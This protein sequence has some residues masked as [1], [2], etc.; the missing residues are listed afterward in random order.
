MHPQQWAEA[1]TLT[2]K[3]K[4]VWVHVHVHI[5][6]HITEMAQLTPLAIP[7]TPNSPSWP[8]D[9]DATSRNQTEGQDM[10]PILVS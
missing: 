4:Y 9:L 7:T 2:G 1:H 3:S 6:N 8:S 5:I 10:H